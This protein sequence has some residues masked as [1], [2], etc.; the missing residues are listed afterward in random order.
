MWEVGIACGV[1]ARGFLALGLAVVFAPCAIALAAEPDSTGSSGS[2]ADSVVATA[3]ADSL[4]RPAS[5][6]PFFE[7]GYAAVVSSSDDRVAPGLG[8]LD[9]GYLHRTGER[10][11]VGGDL[12]FVFHGDGSNWALR[13]RVRRE[14]DRN[15]RADVAAGVVIAGE[16]DGHPIDG[17]GISALAELHY[18]GLLGVSLG[19]Q[20]IHYGTDADTPIMDSPYTGQLTTLSVG[21]RAGGGLGLIVAVAFG[22]AA[23]VALSSL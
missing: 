18:R 16:A 4:R 6:K 14:L 3:P 17:L 11:L 20:S 13:P 2:I 23:I 10:T 1:V 21:A 8:T 22:L 5:G 9:V 15:W 7:A 19:L 12:A